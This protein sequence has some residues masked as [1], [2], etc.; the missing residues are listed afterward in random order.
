MIGFDEISD[1]GT[2]RAV[3]DKYFK[4]VYSW[5]RGLPSCGLDGLIVGK[6]RALSRSLFEFHGEKE[7]SSM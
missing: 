6:S 4:V 7:S 2:L 5:P 1:S 3:F